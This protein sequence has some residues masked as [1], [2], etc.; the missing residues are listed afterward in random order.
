MSSIRKDEFGALTVLV[1]DNAT[2]IGDLVDG[3][4]HNR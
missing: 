3:L 4:V 1:G 2:C